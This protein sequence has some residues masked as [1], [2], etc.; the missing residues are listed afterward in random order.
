MRAVKYRFLE[1]TADKMFEAYG[2]SYEEALENSARAMFSLL[3]KAAPKKKVEFSHSAYNLEELTVQILSDML[4]YSDSNNIVFSK[5]K[6]EKFDREKNFV[7][8][9]A[10][11]DKIK[12]K[13]HI[14]A[15]T[16][17]DLLVEEKNGK[18]RI[19][20]LLDV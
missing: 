9:V 6:V 17:H 10:F 11:G 14:K 16:Y 8:L 5:F 7:S 12:A 1:H 20:I 19:R 18:W 13:D 15:V 3:G 2:K 4:A